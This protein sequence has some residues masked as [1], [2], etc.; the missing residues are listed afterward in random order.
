MESL[1]SE[2]SG[3][4]SYARRR[5]AGTVRPAMIREC[6]SPGHTPR[7]LRFVTQAMRRNRRFVSRIVAPRR[8]C[9]LRRKTGV[10]AP[11]RLHWSPFVL[12]VLLLAVDG[13]SLVYSLGH[14]SMTQ[15]SRPWNVSHTGSSYLPF[16]IRLAH[17]N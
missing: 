8:V 15:S 7:Q 12:L 1:L 5:A 6:S 3:F 4:V 11:H 2:G 9:G 14:P 17:G 10:Q 16:G 13:S